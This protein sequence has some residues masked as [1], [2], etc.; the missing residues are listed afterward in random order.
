MEHGIVQFV[1][2]N[3]NPKSKTVNLA[4]IYVK[5]FFKTFWASEG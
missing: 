5:A 1:K 4:A 3:H 2:K